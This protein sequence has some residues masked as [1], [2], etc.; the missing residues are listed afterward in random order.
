MQV[1]HNTE[2][3]MRIFATIVLVPVI[4]VNL[5]RELKII[6]ILAGIANFILLFGLII[7]LQECIRLPSQAATVPWSTNF[8]DSMLFV[9]TAMYTFEGQAAVKLF[10]IPDKL[11]NIFLPISDVADGE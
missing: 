5:I 11:H 6:S 9:G 7:I 3:D 8:F 10:T 2:I 4:M 1:F